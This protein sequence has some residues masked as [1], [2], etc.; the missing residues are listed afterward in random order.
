[1][2]NKYKINCTEGFKAD[3]KIKE[4]D[5]KTYIE[6]SAVSDKA[7]KLNLWLTWFEEATATG[8]TFSPTSHIGRTII[9]DWGPWNYHHAC[10]SAPFYSSVDFNDKKRQN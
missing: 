8:A 5:G 4:A 9:P 6:L 10:G 1:M 3:Y 7:G 2:D